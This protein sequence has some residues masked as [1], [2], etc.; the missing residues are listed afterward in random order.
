ME[1]VDKLGAEVCRRDQNGGNEMK[2]GFIGLGNMAKAIIE[3][4]LQQDAVNPADIYVHSVHVT[5]YQPYATAKRLQACA[6]NLQVVQNADVI[7]LA[8]QP[9][10][11]ETVLAPLKSEL[12]NK[13]IPLF[14]LLSGVTIAD[15]ENIIGLAVP[16]IRVMP[17]LNVKIGQGMTALA[18]NTAGEPTA[19]AIATDLFGKIGTVMPLSE[20]DFST[21]VALAGSAPAFAFLFIDEL[22]HAGV[23]YGLT[24][25]QAVE[26]VSQMLIGS[27]ELVR[28]SGDAPWNLIDEVAS[29][30]GSTIAG[31][32]AMQAAGF[33]TA[34]T[35]AVDATIAKDL[36]N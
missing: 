14:S 24:K 13:K 30:G 7:I 4:L 33:E 19:N 20:A 11:K 10:Q 6:N 23:K 5:N 21:F 15:L 29:P 36:E 17:N 22:A 9:Q 26:I 1:T 27:A 16:I 3:G 32:L 2:I 31:V 18:T 8:V 34:V 25:K 28:Q 12:I 35:K